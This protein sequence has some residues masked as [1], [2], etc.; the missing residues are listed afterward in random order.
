MRLPWFECEEEDNIMRIRK[1]ELHNFRMFSHLVL[2]NL[3]SFIL[4]VSENG[5]GKSTILEAIAGIKDD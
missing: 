3:P 4:L 5:L 2:E 1:L